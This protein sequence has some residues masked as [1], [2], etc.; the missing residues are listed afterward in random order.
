MSTAVIKNTSLLDCCPPGPTRGN[1][2][3]ET[4]LCIPISILGQ[5]SP[6]TG[7]DLNM[8]N[9][10]PPWKVLGLNLEQA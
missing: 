7:F 8:Q 6:N 3:S 2:V 9:G 10:I 5:E 4:G 1:S